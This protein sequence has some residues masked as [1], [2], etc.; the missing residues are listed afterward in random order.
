[1]VNNTITA[2]NGILAG[3]WTDHD[4]MTGCTSLI[5][6]NGAV[7]GVDVRG[8]A[9][10]TRETDLL[11]GYNIVDRIHGLILSG[12]SAFG[13]DAASGVMRY[14]EEKGIGY[15]AGVCKVPIVPAAVIFDLTVGDFSVRPGKNEG[16]SACENA[17]ANPL[18][19]G[20]VG[21]G[22]GATVGKAFGTKH[23]MKSGVGNAIVA[24]NDG[25]LVAAVAVVNALGDVYDPATGEI[26]AGAV[27][28]G[29]FCPCMEL[30]G[31]ASAG[32]GNTTIGVV[33]TNAKL[34]REEANKLAS[35]AHD[36]LAMAVRPVHTSYDGDTFF[37]V[38]TMEKPAAD[39]L[40]LMTAC[41]KAVSTAIA[42]AVKHA[43][44]LTKHE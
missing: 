23:A 41:I 2:I 8:S 21:A 1:M 6:P 34:T 35:I 3:H 39:M 16:Y 27:K 42:D 20:S 9:P 12:G 40:P 31:P 26:I 14:L 33:A 37:A 32:F 4:A 24:L 10:G 28:G 11:R 5:F 18:A 7:A 13:L 38:S 36:A 29:K 22:A 25:I 15:D 19:S 30:T 43:G 17:S 44:N